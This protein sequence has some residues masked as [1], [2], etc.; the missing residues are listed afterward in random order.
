[1]NR[2]NFLQ[3]SI[4]AAS[5]IGL[6]PR[7]LA[8]QMQGKFYRVADTAAGKLRGIEV[9]GVFQFRGVPYGAST[10]GANRFMPPRP[11]APWS[12]IRDAYGYGE[13]TPQPY[14]SPSH[15]FG[16]L[17]DFDLH[18]GAMGE[19]CLNLNVWTPGLDGKKRP[20]LVYFH[21]GGLS[22]GSGNH[23]LYVGDRLA[24]YADVV[25]VTVN[26]RLSAFGYVNLADLGAPSE[27]ADA[28]NAGILD[29]AQSLEWVR[30]NIAGFG[31][32]PGRVMIF[33]QSGG[34]TKVGA[35][36][37]LD[38]ARGLF[39]SAAIQSGG[40]ALASRQDSAAAAEQLLT[41]LG[42]G[43]DWKKLQQLPPETVLE[44]QIAIGTFD[45]ISGKPPTRPQPEFTAVLDG[46]NFTSP[47]ADPASLR[48]SA[49]V[50]LIVGYCKDD[51]GWPMT[52]FDLTDA[53]LREVAARLA[54]PDRADE[55]VQLYMEHYPNAS[56]FILQASMLTDRNLL[57]AVTTVAERRAALGG[58][59]YVYR[60]D[61]PSQAMNGMFGA[62]HGMDMC[63]VFHITHQPTLGG[64]TPISREMA[65]RMSTAW[66]AFAHSGDPN[67]KAMP[68]W[69]PYA[70]PRRQTM[71]INHPEQRLIDD[72]NGP[73]RHFWDGVAANATAAAKPARRKRK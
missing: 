26:H 25:V 69:E 52:N 59:T 11:V 63:L 66:S 58:K 19:D 40:L 15:P 8:Q 42:V 14:A 64:E 61:W 46:R 53:G 48:V 72:P 57:P 1:M 23:D 70:A 68:H 56:P 22:T 3:A 6:Q 60:F 54:G 39:H 45:W 38:R 33:G 51:S 16:N 20:V 7:A 24:R 18:A 2:R 5:L 41:A 31:G 37:A 34:G 47:L 73:F 27:F 28:G 12:G 71:V 49:E 55:A 43:R 65:D 10:A 9:D 4:G 44:A 62:V 17:I 32:D 50:P 36:M 30:D 13:I 67:S 21:G 35:I 29:L